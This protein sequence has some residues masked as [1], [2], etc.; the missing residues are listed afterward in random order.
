MKLMENLTDFTLYSKNGT[1]STRTVNVTN[2]CLGRASTRDEQAGK[3]YIEGVRATG[4]AIY[5]VPNFCRKSRYLLTN[6]N[7]IEVQ[8]WRTSC[9]VEYVTMVDHGEVLISVGSD[10]NDATL[11]GLTTKPL[12]TVADTAKS[13]QVCPASVAKGAWLYSDVKDHWDQLWLKSHVRIAGKDV[14]YQNFQVTQLRSPESYFKSFPELKNEG[15]VFLS[16][17]SAAVP[18][19]PP[20]LYNVL[21]KEGIF[22]DNFNIAIHDPVLKRTISHEFA[23]SH[24]TWPDSEISP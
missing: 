10:N 19:H 17:S 15:T 16:G 23:I 7:A 3:K 24:L 1:S 4:A 6:E 12:G 11:L 9:E 13:K 2:V 5:N 22:P 18:D 21:S 20:N 8:E 14:Q